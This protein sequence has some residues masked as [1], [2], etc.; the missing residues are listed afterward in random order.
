MTET[1]T[2]CRTE[3]GVTVGLIDSLITICRILRRRDLSSPAIQEALK[4][5]A[6]DEDLRFCLNESQRRQ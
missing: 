1:V 6:Q 4:D 3:E 2:D 5:L